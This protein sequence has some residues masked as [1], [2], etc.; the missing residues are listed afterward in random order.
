LDQNSNRITYIDNIRV[1]VIVL[2]LMQHI[3]VTYSVL[4]MVS[5]VFYMGPQKNSQQKLKKYLT[6]HNMHNI[7]RPDGLTVRSITGTHKRP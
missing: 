5:G 2:V 4:K 1:F 7:I 3:S 6:N